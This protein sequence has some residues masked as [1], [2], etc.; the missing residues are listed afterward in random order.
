MEIKQDV[1]A[2]TRILA[3]RRLMARRGN[4]RLFINDNFKS[5]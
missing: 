5:F 1:S 2:N 3:L 4:P